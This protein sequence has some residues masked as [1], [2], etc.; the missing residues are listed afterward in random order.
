[1]NPSPPRR[2]A[3]ALL[4]AARQSPALARLVDNVQ[5]SSQRL[6]R[7][8]PLLPP[9]LRTAVQAGPLEDGQWCLL[10]QSNAV[11]AKLRQMLPLMQSHLQASDL[12]VN[13]IRIKVRARQT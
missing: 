2:H 12:P 7:V 6:E 8:R 13:S 4:D 11:A 9:A 1:M 5:A 10:A 3:I